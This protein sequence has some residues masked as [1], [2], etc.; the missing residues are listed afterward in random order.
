MVGDT[1]AHT[2]D[3]AGVFPYRCGIHANMQGLVVVQ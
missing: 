1:F 3:S 2:F